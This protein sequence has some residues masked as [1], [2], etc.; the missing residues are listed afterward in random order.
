MKYIALVIGSSV[1]AACGGG[2]G[3]G[4]VAASTPTA[5]AA[6]A[7]LSSAN[8][9]VAAQDTSSSSFAPLAGAQALTGAQV[10]D[11]S[12][13]FNTARQQM[14]LLPAYIAA[15]SASRTLTG[16][17]QSETSSCSNGGSLT[18]SVND[19]D[20]NNVASAGDSATISSNG[21]NTG[22]GALSGT[23][24]FVINNLSGTFNSSNYSAGITMSFTSFSVSASQYSASLNGSLSLSATATG[25][26]SSRATVTT[27][28]L[29]IAATYAGATRTRSLA[30]YSATYTRSPNATYTYLTSYEFNGYMTS[31]ALS[32]QAIA[33][34]TTTPIVTRYTDSYPSSGVLVISGANNTKVRL[35]A[36]SNTQVSEE[37]DANGD[38]AY[39]TS[40][41][42]AWNSL[43]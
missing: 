39:E 28:S 1:L 6:T 36:L 26:N 12:V 17:V 7:I 16:V 13:L 20:N 25:V 5:L 32:S 31:S 18:V 37:L 22:S 11:E 15:A 27:P 42:V 9:H 4:G 3:G 24:G 33:F 8:Q 21:C 29:S 30:N 38:G 43:K 40:T 41:V 19:A 34:A 2:G 14:D 23:I 35:T 10:I